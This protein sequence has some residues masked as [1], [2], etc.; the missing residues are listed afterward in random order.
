VNLTSRSDIISA[1]SRGVDTPLSG[2][3]A[4]LPVRKQRTWSGSVSLPLII[5]QRPPKRRR[6][7]L[8]RVGN[9]GF[10]YPWG[11][12][13]FGNNLTSANVTKTGFL[14]F[15]VLG[16]CLAPGAAVPGLKDARKGQV[17]GNSKIKHGSAAI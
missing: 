11:F 10:L 16:Q 6:A 3:A 5:C 15:F 9:R 17:V 7:M 13:F 2:T 4:Q 8:S 1:A 12:G 14:R